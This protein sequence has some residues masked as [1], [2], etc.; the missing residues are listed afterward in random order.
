M[1]LVPCARLGGSGAPPSLRAG[2][3]VGCLWG[4]APPAFLAAEWGGHLRQLWEGWGQGTRGGLA[5][6]VGAF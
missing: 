3:P 1:R 4:G 2:A 5:P 6:G